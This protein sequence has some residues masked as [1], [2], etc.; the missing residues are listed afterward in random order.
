MAKKRFGEYLVSIKE[1][2]REAVSALLD[3]QRVVR[4]EIGQLAVR[5]GYLKEPELVRHLSI[6]LGIPLFDAEAVT[7]DPVLTGKVPKK[8]ALKLGIFPAGIGSNGEL[9][10]A[11]SGAVSMIALQSVS[12]LVNRPVVLQLVSRGL[13]RK[14]QSE[15]YSRQ[16]DT[17]IRVSTLGA[18]QE[19]LHQ[20]TEVVEKL[21]L[22]AINVEASDLHIEPTRDDLVV[23]MRIDGVMTVTETLPVTLADKIISRV[24]VLSQLDIAE[25]RMPQDGAFFFKPQR[26]DVDIEG[27]N[28]RTSTL[29]VVYGEKAVMRLL[30]AHDSAAYL[31]DIGLEEDSLQ[32]FRRLVSMPY[33]IVL[34]TGPT[35]SGKSTTLYA[36]LRAIR[37]ETINLTTLEDPVEMKMSGINQTQINPG[38]KI[39]FAGALRAILRQDP[40]IIMVGEIRDGDT[41]KVS[42]QAAI[43]GHLVLSTLHTNDAPSSFTRLVDMG[44]E[45]FLV[46]SSLRGVLAQRLV[47]RVCGHCAAE[48]ETSSSE[49]RMLGLPEDKPFTIYRGVGCEACGFKGYRGRSGIFELLV[50]DDRLGAMVAGGE[51]A[52]RIRHYAV[53]RGNF[54]NLRQDGI[55]KVRQG[56]T[57]PEEVVRVTMS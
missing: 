4:E 47:R 22:R 29:P 44:A 24:K 3:E 20:I 41:V 57:T 53:E 30:P 19:D 8:L 21:L 28:I 38:P 23:R 45:P 54:R 7:L 15:Q 35:G 42:L 18:D 46:A 36:V 27:V 9:V 51:P 6:F 49:L 11:C 5:R 56:V 13:L 2:T 34:V 14:L 31:E 39:S 43:T 50:M 26:L 48:A 40:D 10:C 55:I 1:L 17:T 25:K 33:G 32:E 37:S 52:E 12:R 16:Y